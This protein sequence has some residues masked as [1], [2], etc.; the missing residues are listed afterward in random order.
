MSP[1]PRAAIAL[2]HRRVRSRSRVPPPVGD[3]ARVARRGRHC[4]RHGARPAPAPR[5]PQHRDRARARG[6]PAVAHDRDRSTAREPARRAAPGPAA[7]LHD[8]AGDRRGAAST[9]RVVAHRRGAHR[10]PPVAARRRG[11]LGLGTCTFDADGGDRPA[12][13]PR[14]VRRAAVGDRDAAR[15]LPRS[16]TAHRA[17]RSASAP[18]SSRSATTSPTTTCVRS[19]GRPPRASAGR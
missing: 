17:A 1:S 5:A 15:P 18:S 2:R 16:R 13:V 3:R 6:V 12:R 19:T 7:R 8:R 4:R 10:L 11:P 9:R 14:R